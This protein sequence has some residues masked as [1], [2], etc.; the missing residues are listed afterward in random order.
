M[1]GRHLL[2]L[3]LACA[4]GV[5]VLPAAGQRVD[6]GRA[7]AISVVAFLNVNVVALDRAGVLENQTV[8][9]R[10]GRISEIG[11]AAKTKVPKGATRIE[12][13]GLIIKSFYKLLNV[14]PFAAN[15]IHARRATKGDPMVAL[16]YE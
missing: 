8:I 1:I 11:A 7:A 3:L 4:A 13:A 2:C 6:K 5:G 12:G 9:A 14:E 15:Y 10:D 16:R